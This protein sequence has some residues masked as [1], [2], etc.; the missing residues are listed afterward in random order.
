MQ[1]FSGLSGLGRF[2]KVQ[3]E[4]A[5]KFAEQKRKEIYGEFAGHN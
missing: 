3:L 1:N 5:G 2:P 4:Q